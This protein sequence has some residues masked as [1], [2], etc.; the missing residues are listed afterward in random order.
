MYI[1][2][3]LSLFFQQEV[4]LGIPAQWGGVRMKAVVIDTLSEV[5]LRSVESLNS[6]SCTWLGI[7][8]KANQG[9]GKSAAMY[10]PVVPR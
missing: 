4:C 7:R 9:L 8:A 10:A 5:V 6:A 2:T 3:S 1:D